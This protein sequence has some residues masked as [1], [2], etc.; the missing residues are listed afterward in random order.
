M[1]LRR[2][3]GFLLR[4]SAPLSLV[5]ADA[6]TGLE[7]QCLIERGQLPYSDVRSCPRCRGSAAATWRAVRAYYCQVAASEPAP[8]PSLAA[9][10]VC[11][12]FCAVSA[13]TVRLPS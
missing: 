13:S 2:S 4:I 3:A 9:G 11:G 12:R 8:W 7:P 1:C 6:E 5:A 10:T